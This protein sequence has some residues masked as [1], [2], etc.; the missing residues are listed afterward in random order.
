M[1][2]KPPMENNLSTW[3]MGCNQQRQMFPSNHGTIPYTFA[4]QCLFGHHTFPKDE[5]PSSFHFSPSLNHS[6]QVLAYNHELLSRQFTQFS[7][8]PAAG[9]VITSAVGDGACYAA[10]A[11]MKGSVATGMVSSS[12]TQNLSP[13]KTSPSCPKAAGRKRN[14]NRERHSKIITAQGLRDRRMR[15]S[16]DV[17][18]EF[19]GLQDKLGFDKASKTVAWLLRKSKPAIK[20]LYKSKSSRRAYPYSTSESEDMSGT[21]ETTYP[22]VDQQDEDL[23]QKSL[24]PT[25]SKKGIQESQKATYCPIA[26]ESRAIA[27]AKAR[28]RTKEKM[29][30]RFGKSK[31]LPEVSTQ[32]P[33]QLRPLSPLGS[34]EE[35]GSHITHDKKPLELG[36]EITEPNKLG[37]SVFDFHQH[38][39]N[40]QGMNASSLVSLICSDIMDFPE[41]WDMDSA[42]TRSSCCDTPNMHLFTGKLRSKK[43]LLP[44]SLE[45]HMFAFSIL[46]IMRCMSFLKKKN[47]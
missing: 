16:V 1:C 43:E 44:C 37:L 27:R 3:S 8:L 25:P 11:S 2:S 19:F 26:R 23:K 14:S 21:D 42:R 30:K 18:H 20:E 41:N 9:N 22:V 12:T 47:L 4:E 28:E 10:A 15:L 17:A 7:H 36:A 24:V 38:L 32:D 46:Y 6:N 29:T 13:N 35:S 39:T 34:T 5:P 40:P 31:Q 45:H 33:S